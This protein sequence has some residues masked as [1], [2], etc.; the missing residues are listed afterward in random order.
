MKTESILAK[1]EKARKSIDRLNG[2]IAK[3]EAKI[4]KHGEE[5]E[6]V[7]AANIAKE[8]LGRKER[9]LARLLEQLEANAAK[10]AKKALFEAELPECLI[11]FRLHLVESWDAHDK[12]ERDAIVE[13][14]DAYW[15]EGHGSYGDYIRAVE[16][17]DETIHDR[18]FR[19][20]TKM[21]AN[22]LKRVE[23]AVGKVKSYSRLYVHNGNWLEGGS[24]LNGFVEGE[25]GSCEVRSIL[26]GGY[27]IQRLHVRVLVI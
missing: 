6:Y 24:A 23:K 26:A 9:E 11:G 14:G 25:N 27:N 10:D 18:N 5:F 2:V 7:C 22:L 19:D 1:I 21:V 13:Q 16:L 12:A 15:Q 17:T 8:D 3:N 4:A 20:A